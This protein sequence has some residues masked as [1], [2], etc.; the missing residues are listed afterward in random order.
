[1]LYI[2]Y[3]GKIGKVFT[4]KEGEQIDPLLDPVGVLEA[5]CDLAK[6]IFSRTRQFFSRLFRIFFPKK[7]KE[8]PKHLG[9]LNEICPR[10]K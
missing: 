10:D 4:V 5:T 3:L 9:K 8:I 7:K 2:G 1:M 6:D